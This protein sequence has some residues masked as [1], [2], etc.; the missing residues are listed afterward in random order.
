MS[1][2][3]QINQMSKREIL[4]NLAHQQNQDVANINR[5]IIAL[6][7]TLNADPKKLAECFVSLEGNQEYA[8]KFNAALQE[9]FAK[10]REK[11]TEN[12]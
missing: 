12:K 2:R 6:A 9:A 10:E 8:N 1:Q 7:L 11:N 3:S 4:Q 5:L